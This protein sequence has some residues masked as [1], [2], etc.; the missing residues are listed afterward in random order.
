[1]HYRCPQCSKLIEDKNSRLDQETTR[2]NCGHSFILGFEHSPQFDLPDKIEIQLTGPLN[3]SNI[4]V[5]VDYG[6]YRFSPYI[7]KRRGV[8]Y[9]DQTDV[10]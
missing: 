5:T 7:N 8:G 6:E 3:T 1:M 10:Y 4:V 2:P 9:F